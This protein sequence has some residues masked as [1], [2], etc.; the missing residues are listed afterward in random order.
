MLR[1][2][3]IT[4]TVNTSSSHVRESRSTSLTES[5]TKARFA[6]ALTV[7][8][9]ANITDRSVDVTLAWLAFW[10]I[11][12]S[13]GALITVLSNKTSLTLAFSS[14][15]GAGASVLVGVAVANFAWLW[16]IPSYSGWTEISVGALVTVDSF[17]VITTVHA[18]T[19]SFV[20]SLRV[21]GQLVVVDLLVVVAFI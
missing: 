19:S 5:A 18:D 15:L 13:G 8:G 7:F 21:H 10:S 2:G 4:D 20:I 6:W 14:L 16:F 17:C 11:V 9:K 3:S 12:V 1:T